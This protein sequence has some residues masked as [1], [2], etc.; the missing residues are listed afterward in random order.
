V[1]V[2][3]AHDGDTVLLPA[4]SI[5]KSNIFPEEYFGPKFNINLKSEFIQILKKKK[6]EE[7]EEKKKKKRK[8]KEEK[9]EEEEKKRKTKKK[10]REEKKEEEKEKKKKHRTRKSVHALKCRYN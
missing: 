10:K 5:S 4:Y 6:K 1:S 2:Q 8:K 7:E 9:T 3:L